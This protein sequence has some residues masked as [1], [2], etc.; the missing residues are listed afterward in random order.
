MR[1][2]WIVRINAAARQNGM[3]YGAFDRPAS[4]RPTSS[5]TARSWPTSPSATARRSVAIAEASRR[6]PEPIAAPD[7]RPLEPSTSHDGRG[8]VILA[9]R[10]K[11]RVDLADL[12]RDLEALRDEALVPIA[13]APDVGDARGAR[14]RRPRQEGPAD[15]GP[16]RHRRTARRGSA[17]R[18]A[19]SPTPSASAI[20]AALAE[21]GTALRGSELEARL[22]GRGGRR[23]D[24]RPADPARHAPSEHRG[25][26]RDRRDLRAVRV[27]GRTRA[28]RSR[29]T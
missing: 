25:D 16:A 7:A 2:L 9:R 19:R 20:E 22:R 18:S 26:A 3:T 29:T 27:R 13:A 12:T 14:A 10:T 21:R 1:E 23:H 6:A 24:A 17:A 15:G 8:F 5:S 11:E 28:P 4:R